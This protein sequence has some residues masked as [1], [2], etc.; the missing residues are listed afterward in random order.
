MLKHATLLA[1]ALSSFAANAAVVTFEQSAGDVLNNSNV[2]TGDQFH[3]YGLGERWREA[4]FNVRTNDHSHI[5]Q[6]Y[7]D[8]GSSGF[9]VHGGSTIT[10]DMG[11]LAFNLQSFDV[12]VKLGNWVVTA[13][14]GT[15]LGFGADTAVDFTQGFG[16]GFSGITSFTVS[17]GNSEFEFDNLRLNN[18]VPLPSTLALLLPAFAGL[19]VARLRRRA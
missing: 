5:H 12:Y 13:S 19:G 3:S 16:S 1:L 10:V 6:D 9:D 15:V 2:L 14:S 17:G 11:G 4:G 8:T 7:S 18:A